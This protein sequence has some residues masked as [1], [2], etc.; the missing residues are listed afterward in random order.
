MTRPTGEEEP[1]TNKEAECEVVFF[2][3]PPGGFLFFE[4]RPTKHRHISYV[5]VPKESKIPA[6]VHQLVF[7]EYPFHQARALD[8]KI[9]TLISIAFVDQNSTLL[10]GGETRIA[11][12][13]A[14]KL[15]YDPP[16]STRCARVRMHPT[17]ALEFSEIESGQIDG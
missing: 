12:Q 9:H 13:L 8:F 11:L 17:L 6:H 4:E 14:M 1:Q 10:R 7:N 3:F 15:N 5:K 2:F 16:L